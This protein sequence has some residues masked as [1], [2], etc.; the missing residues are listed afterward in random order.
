[1]F[2][3]M[4]VVSAM[5][6]LLVAA[7][8]VMA[9]VTTMFYDGISG[10]AGGPYTY[11]QPGYE[12]VAPAAVVHTQANG[13]GWVGNGPGNAGGVFDTVAPNQEMNLYGGMYTYN[14]YAVNGNG[15]DRYGQVMARIG[16]AYGQVIRVGLFGGQNGAF[17]G[18]SMWD[19]ASNSAAEV[20]YHFTNNL[21]YKD[22]TQTF[23]LASA[24]NDQVYQNLT[25]NY[26]LVAQTYDVWLDSTE[27]ASGIGYGRNISSIQSIAI[28]SCIFDP[29]ATVVNALDSWQWQTS[30]DTAFTSYANELPE[31]A[32][33]VLLGLGVSFLR[34]RAA[35]A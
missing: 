34:K 29:A 18:A 8:P 33:L 5:L 25:I 3:R 11:W 12:G 15:T 31:P 6:G 35:K 30:A 14:T 22:N 28:G 26:D 23:Q 10:T 21:Y 4:A 1:M 13:L 27:V 19:A 32:T 20:E 17:D 24:T 2:K 7:C 16:H 9:S